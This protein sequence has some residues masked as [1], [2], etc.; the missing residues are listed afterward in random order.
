MIIKNLKL[1]ASQLGWRLMVLFLL[2]LLAGL[3]EG[4][5]VSM[6]L[7]LLQSDIGESSNTL[8]RM[9]SGLFNL[10]NQP[11]HGTN[12]L[13]LL[14]I[15]FFV[16]AVI[17][18]IQTWYQ[19]VLLSDHL[20]YMRGGLIRSILN[21]DYLHLTRYDAG[22]LTNAVVRE[23]QA[24]NAGMRNLIDLIVALVMAS[25][26]ILL[27]ILL[28]PIL[29]LFLVALA[30]P[31]AAL[32]F[33]MIRK[34]RAASIRFT[35]LHGRQES[36]LIEGIRNVKFVKATGRVP[37]ISDRMTNETDRVSQVFKRL[38]ILGG[39][40]RYAPEPLVVFVMAGIIIVATRGFDQ[41]ITEILFLMF[42]FFQSAKYMLRIQ[43]TLRQFIEATGS[44][45]L[46]QELKS[47]LDANAVV[48]PPN[49]IPPDLSAGI[50]LS[51]VSVT[52]PKADS[53]ALRGIDLSIPNRKTVALVGASGSGKTTVAN[54][55]CGLI[56]PS[57]GSIMLGGDDYSTLRLSE[58]QKSVGYVTQESAVFNGTLS[59]NVTFWEQD[60][61]RQRVDEI[62]K[63]LEL[64]GVGTR[65]TNGEFADHMIG[66]DG[67]QLSGGERQRLSIARELYRH[68]EI[69]ILDE[70][71]SA[72][73]SELE[74][75]IDEMLE[76]QRGNRTFLI[77][78][79]RL[80]TVKSA[81]L[82][83]V[84]DHGAVV[85]SGSFDELVE[86]GGGFARM[87]KLQSF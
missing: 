27:P 80:S 54:L 51:N 70:A 63:Q 22:Y 10:L 28:Q 2:L 85:E 44:L 77:I 82:I 40:T 72:L 83:Y 69:L 35:E 84:L 65:T 53:P 14:V 68:S 18:V 32:S 46:H 45:L 73:D 31:I 49:A 9:I 11:T 15:F 4:F 81:D 75:K 55:V 52:Y 59:E 20:S 19:A 41:P 30:I 60:P 6:I 71:T 17:L 79:H 74:Q 86:A 8:S 7:P 25:I 38:F 39:I 57:S 48:D 13:V 67:A 64:R 23:V 58:L 47:K 26:Y 66:G 36:F 29:T 43:S 1:F 3:A 62:L 5:G 12:I 21:A 78:A 61:D 50:T 33:L 24:I 87:V 56:T 34:T 76:A 42:L 37:V 16:R